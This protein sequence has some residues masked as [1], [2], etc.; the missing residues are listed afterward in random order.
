MNSKCV[1]K[2]II[3]SSLPKTVKLQEKQS[4]RSTTHHPPYPETT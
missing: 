4:L 2:L 1:Y 3:D